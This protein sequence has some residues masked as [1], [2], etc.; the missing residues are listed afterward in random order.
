[1]KQPTAR[2]IAMDILTKVEQ[3]QAYSNLLLNQTLQKYKLERL[4]ANLTT[5]IVYGTIQRR[6]TIDYFL[7]R[8]AAKGID[9]L[10]P[11]VRNL[12]RLSFYQLYYLER[13]PIH[14]IVNEAV[15]IA[16]RKGHKGISG[17][18]N[19]ILRNVERNKEQL[20]IPQDLPVATRISLTHSHPEWMVARW[21]KQFG[22]ETTEAICRANNDASHVS[23]RVN[24]MRHNR[25]TFMELLRDK[26]FDVKPSPVSRQG[27]IVESG[28]NMAHTP[29]FTGGDL[30]IQDE[31]SM[32]VAEAV[33]PKPG[34]K[35]LDCC[36]AP[37]GKTAHMAELMNNQGNVW[38]NDIHPHK[39]K[40]IDEQAHRLGL[41]CIQTIVS[42][43]KHLS[44]KFS[45][46]TFDRILVDAPCSGLGVIRRKPDLKWSK[47]KEE[48]KQIPAVQLDIL[49]TASRLLHSDGTLVYS[50]CTLEDE[51][52]QHVIEKFLA[53]NPDFELDDS[54]H[55]NQPKEW[56][57]LF[58]L[59]AGMI[60]ILPHF[61]GSDG[62]F[63]A[64]MKKKQQPK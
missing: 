13:I 12:L 20:T 4:E 48:I 57:E 1:M 6:N 40:L 15:N 50:T 10:Q 38:A 5:E 36:A 33:D 61:F 25:D 34:M 41:D 56:L 19:G 30:S 22:E 32:L 47:A 62:F 42:D 9:K 23:V 43:A 60:R 55:R 54:I 37:G 21:I 2:E 26:E 49:T 14:A 53:N 45:G 64:K 63:I 51:E 59:P 24:A 39:Q 58:D 8:F 18:V 35:V 11:W 28:G 29:W 31:S 16:K 7:N 52:N 3:Q 17:M 46:Q 44:D 27:L